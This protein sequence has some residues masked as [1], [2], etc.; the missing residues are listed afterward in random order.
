MT[1]PAP[2]G[3]SYV[4]V[5]GSVESTRVKIGT[6]VNPKKRLKELQTGNPERLELRWCTSGGRELETMLHQAFAAHRVEGEWFDF[7]D[8]QPVGA[9]PA[10]VHQLSEETTPLASATSRTASRRSNPRAGRGEHL[11]TPERLAGIV[12]DVVLGVVRPEPEPD[13]EDDQEEVPIKKRSALDHDVD[14]LMGSVYGPA[15]TRHARRAVA[16][17]TGFAA[18]GGWPSIVLLGLLTTVT[19]PIAAFLALRAIT[20]DIW[21]VR[22]LPILA[23]VGYGL[24]G[25]LGFD[26]LIRDFVLSRLPVE[27]IEAFGRTYFTQAAITSAWLLAVASLALCLFGYAQ[28]VNDHTQEERAKVIAKVEAKR[29]AATRPPV[30]GTRLASSAAAGLDATGAAEAIS[31]KPSAGGIA[32]SPLIADL[33]RPVPRQPSDTVH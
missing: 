30:R 17:K 20:R 22:K 28:E 26:K 11:I 9:I 8:V 7:G 2:G 6:S 18:L 10:V 31:R 4:Y 24:W 1:S 25:P 5:I 12:R 32:P 27:D 15:A 3:D 16:G 21:P 33:T 19:L 23:L 14:R 13:E 29:K